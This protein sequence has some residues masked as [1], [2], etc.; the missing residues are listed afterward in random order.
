MG[1]YLVWDVRQNPGGTF[2]YL[3]SS[4][5]NTVSSKSCFEIVE[6]YLIL[7]YGVL[8]WANR[9]NIPHESHAVFDMD[10]KGDV[11]FTRLV[12]FILFLFFL[13]LRK[14]ISNYTGVFHFW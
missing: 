4:I 2:R 1:T 13:F 9:T 3:A 8:G 14:R 11:L 7:V 10:L 6:D 5:L 12:S